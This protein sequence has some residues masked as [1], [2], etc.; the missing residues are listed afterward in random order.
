MNPY[1]YGWSQPVTSA[2]H[3]RPQAWGFGYKGEWRSVSDL[4]D[5]CNAQDA[6]MRNLA[7]SVSEVSNNPNPPD[8]SV[9]GPF[10]EDY[11][12]LITRYQK[13]RDIAQKTI[14]KASSIWNLAVPN[15]TTTATE[16]YNQ[17]LDAVNPR[18]GENTWSEGDGS[19]DDLY[20]RIT[21]MGASLANHEPIP[22]PKAIDPMQLANV[23]TKV[24]EEPPKLATSA[25]TEGIKGIAKT[26]GSTIESVAK[27]VGQGLGGATG[28]LSWQTIAIIAGVV[29]LGIIVL[30]KMLS[31][32][33]AGHYLR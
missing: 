32:T 28:Q 19:Y 2:S 16:E 33:P 15:A 9:L 31:L 17:L 26:T 4:I 6:A 11:I 7:R 1:S 27:G 3:S 23:A 14:D 5:I 8:P 10:I 18:W 21:K 24:I 20:S 13:A 29:G 12:K 22:Q 25:F 30:P